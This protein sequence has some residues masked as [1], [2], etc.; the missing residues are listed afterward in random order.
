MDKERM[1][2]MEAGYSEE[3]LDKQANKLADSNS[4]KAGNIFDPKK[5]IIKEEVILDTQN[6]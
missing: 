1:P 4:V 2:N 6:Q 5:K 3:E